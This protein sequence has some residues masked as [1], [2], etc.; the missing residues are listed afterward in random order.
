M[1]EFEW[2]P[3]KAELNVSRHSV[4]FEE[5]STVFFDDYARQFYDD[6]HS[7]EE[8]RFLMLGL[9]NRSRVL[10]VVHCERDGQKFESDSRNDDRE[11]KEDDETEEENEPTI[12]IISAR[13]ATAAE[14]AFY[15]GP[16]P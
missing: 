5:A 11:I 8:D 16:L 7:A 9:S 1:I 15:D 2:D 13:E 4:T 6:E 3:D 12:R 14:R 10:M